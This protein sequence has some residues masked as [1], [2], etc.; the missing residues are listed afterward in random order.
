MNVSQFQIR[1]GFEGYRRAW[2]A[3]TKPTIVP[4]VTRM[5]RMQGF[6]PITVGSKVTRS[7][8]VISGH[9]PPLVEAYRFSAIDGEG[10]FSSA[11]A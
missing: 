2:P 9:W 6:P 3:A 10:W 11:G 1:I 8:H 7:F 4:T 5:P